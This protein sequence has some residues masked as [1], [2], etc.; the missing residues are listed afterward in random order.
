MDQV[1][2]GLPRL[3]T[4]AGFTPG[5]EGAGGAQSADIAGGARIGVVYRA[6]EQADERSHALCGHEQ[7]RCR[8]GEALKASRVECGEVTRLG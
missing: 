2:L 6:I 1:T 5:A 3:F 4:I 7:I 8:G